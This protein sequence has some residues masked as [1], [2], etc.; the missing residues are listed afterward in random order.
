MIK[1]CTL[2]VAAALIC[3]RY[4]PAFASIESNAQG[5]EVDARFWGD[6]SWPK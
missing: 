3:G 1:T 5:K 4:S 2:A 6:A